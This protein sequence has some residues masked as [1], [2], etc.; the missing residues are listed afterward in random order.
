MTPLAGQESNLADGEDDVESILRV[1][2]PGRTVGTP[3]IILRAVDGPRDEHAFA[4]RGRSIDL[5]EDA[6]FAPSPYATSVSVVL[7]L[8][9]RA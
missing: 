7:S 1:I 9:R 8:A 4:H 6:A 3:H 5:V 2:R